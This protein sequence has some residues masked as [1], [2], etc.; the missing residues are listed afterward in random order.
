MGSVGDDVAHRLA[1][2]K[3]RSVRLNRT[4]T[5]IMYPAKNTPDIQ[6]ALVLVSVEASV[7]VLSSAAN[8]E[9]PTMPIIRA[10]LI[11]ATSTRGAGVRRLAPDHGGECKETSEADGEESDAPAVDAVASDRIEDGTHCGRADDTAHEADKRMHGERGTALTGLGGTDGTGGQRRRIARHQD[12]VYQAK[13]H[14][15]TPR[16]AGGKTND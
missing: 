7:K 12:T 8:A 2:A 6:P 4:G 1:I 14:C 13:R 3:H 11:A 9:T 16:D 10:A 5:A 15:E